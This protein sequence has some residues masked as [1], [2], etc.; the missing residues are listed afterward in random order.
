MGDRRQKES[1]AR[2]QGYVP[3]SLRESLL[4]VG[5]AWSIEDKLEDPEAADWTESE[6]VEE[7]LRAALALEW[8]DEK[9][10]SEPMSEREEADFH[11]RLKAEHKAQKK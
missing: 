9:Y 11:A 10:G 3:K 1:R 7:L 5:R 4:K 2:V 6:V 8:A